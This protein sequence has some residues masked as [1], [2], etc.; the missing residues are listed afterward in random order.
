MAQ[1]ANADRHVMVRF[2]NDAVIDQGRTDAE[3]RKVYRDMEMCEVRF[4]GDNT[5]TFVAPAHDPVFMHRPKFG[6]PD[7]GKGFLTC[8]E[9]YADAYKAWK[10]KGEGSVAGTPLAHAPFLTPAKVR[11]MEALNIRTV[12]ALGD[13]NGT[14]IGKYHFRPFVEQAKVFLGKAEEAA[15]VARANA[16]R[17]A[18]EARF[19][20]LEERL[21]AAEAKNA[22]AGDE[23]SRWDDARL[24]AFIEEKS[25]QAPRANAAR[26]KLEDAARAILADEAEYA[27]IAAA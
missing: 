3:G 22:T 16:E 11:E 10:A 18:L 12:E 4:P 2:Y 23:V 24:R 21:R 27:R 19:A 8:A 7:E 9:R 26:G 14:A 13:L 20:E 15:A 25:G 1:A 6:D 17:D 5:R